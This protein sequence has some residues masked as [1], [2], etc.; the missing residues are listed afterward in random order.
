MLT[1]RGRFLFFVQCFSS[2]C[3]TAGAN[4]V[5]GSWQFWVVCSNYEFVN[6]WCSPG[7]GPR[8]GEQDS[9]EH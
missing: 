6:G 1:I 5:Y 4:G 3:V 8:I 2:M 9:E 7:V